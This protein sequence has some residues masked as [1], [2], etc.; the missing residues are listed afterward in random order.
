ME[1][2]DILIAHSLTYTG[3]KQKKAMERIL[4]P[5]PAPIMVYKDEE[6][7]VLHPFEEADQVSTTSSNKRQDGYKRGNRTSKF[8]SHLAADAE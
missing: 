7:G 8:R 5:S 3:H 1:R 6:I 4:N 2:H